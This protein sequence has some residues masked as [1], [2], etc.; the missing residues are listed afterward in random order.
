MVLCFFF[1]SSF[2]FSAHAFS[3]PSFSFSEEIC[4]NTAWGSGPASTTQKLISNRMEIA[5]VPSSV[6]V[7]KLL[8]HFQGNGSER[9]PFTA[10][11]VNTQVET[12]MCVFKTFAKKR[13]VNHTFPVTTVCQSPCILAPN[14][15]FFIV[16]SYKLFLELKYLLYIDS[17]SD[18]DTLFCLS[19]SGR[20]HMKWLYLGCLHFLWFVFFSSLF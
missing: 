3:N 2:F 12:V 14:S 6:T 10:L 9:W 17:T 11:K 18:L 4:V 13:S 15:L 19:T 5:A 1:F 20:E 7:F 8:A 16:T